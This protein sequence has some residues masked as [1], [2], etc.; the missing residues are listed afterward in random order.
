MTGVDI[1]ESVDPNSPECLDAVPRV[2][3]DARNLLG[4]FYQPINI[5]EQRVAG[6]DF[7][8]LPP[9]FGDRHLAFRPDP[10]CSPARQPPVRW[11]SLETR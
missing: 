6:Y 8:H 10:R 7:G 5:A 2:M 4:V 3:R 9:G 1:R 11:R